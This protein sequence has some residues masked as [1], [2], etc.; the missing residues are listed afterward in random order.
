MMWW[1]DRGRPGQSG[2]AR[3]VRLIPGNS[4][5]W[6][7]A[8]GLVGGGSWRLSFWWDSRRAQRCGQH[9]GLAVRS[10]RCPGA[11]DAGPATAGRWL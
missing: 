4:G 9:G 2:G 5:A 7:A 11:S 6:S 3:P 10:A 1:R 8:A